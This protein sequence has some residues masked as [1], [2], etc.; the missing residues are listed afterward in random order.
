[1]SHAT[2]SANQA[3]RARRELYGLLAE[4]F[5]FPTRELGEAISHG[6]L[7]HSIH[8]VTRAL[9]YEVAFERDG[10]E[11]HVD[12]AELEAEYIRLF[13]LPGGGK[14]CP[15]YT[16]VYSPSRRDAMEEILRL[17]RH[18]GVTL[19]NQGR[20]LPDALPTVLEF[21]QYLVLREAA[22]DSVSADQ[23]RAA[24][25][26][27]LQRQLRPWAEATRPRLETRQPG[28]FYAGAVHFAG[29]AFAA[30]ATYLHRL[31]ASEPREPAEYPVRA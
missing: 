22:A 16:G 31:A 9:P 15:L 23:A 26:D 6:A 19:A 5:S 20:D 28:P 18:F 13:D 24:Q 17:Y 30:D 21:Q 10:F 4:L 8:A 7:A 14:T 27:L 12:P 11:V 25:F 1:M 29:Q 2:A 3:L